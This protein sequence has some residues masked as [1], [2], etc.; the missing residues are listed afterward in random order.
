VIGLF[1]L[2]FLALARRR[3]P[4]RRWTSLPAPVVDTIAATLFGA[5]G[6][7]LAGMGIDA[8]AVSSGH[9]AGQ[10]LSAAPVALAAAVIFGI[11]LVRDITPAR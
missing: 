7:W 5:S 11:R 6:V 2:G 3:S 1:A 4:I 8:L 9:G 10:W